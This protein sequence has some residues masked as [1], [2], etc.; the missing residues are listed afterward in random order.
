[1]PGVHIRGHYTV[2]KWRP[3]TERFYSHYVPKEKLKIPSTT[4]L[5]KCSAVIF[6][7]M[8]SIDSEESTEL[9]RLTD[10]IASVK[11]NAP[12]GGVVMLMQPKRALKMPSFVR[13]TS[14]GDAIF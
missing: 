7:K 2:I 4:V 12:A 3:E 14:F 11:Y 9:V 10:R 5:Q 8:S 1:M 13:K 6:L